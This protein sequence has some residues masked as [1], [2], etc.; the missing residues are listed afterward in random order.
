[1]HRYPAESNLRQWRAGWLALAAALPLG[2][3]GGE[4]PTPAMTDAATHEQLAQRLRMAQQDD[5]MQLLPDPA[6]KDPAKNLPRDLLSQSDVLCFGGMATL[7]PKR[8]I[9]R[10]PD[11][12]AQRM[13][14]HRGS[15]LVGWAEFHAQNRGWITT[16]EV[17]RA[18]AEGNEA[19]AA[20][21]TAR[22]KGNSNLVVAT[23]LGGPISVLPLKAPPTKPAAANT[24]AAAAAAAANTVANPAAVTASATPTQP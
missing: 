10:N 8:A 6:G 20:D 1:M 11:A 17:S 24:P 14:Y 2:L 13:E 3:C 23:Y 9:L 5:P 4:S 18:Q 16:V 7:V 22:L 21:V 12:L 19:L 15:A